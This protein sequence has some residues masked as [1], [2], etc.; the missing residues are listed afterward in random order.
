MN[1]MPISK[2]DVLLSIRPEFATKI[3]TGEKTVELRRRFPTEAVT[4]ATAMIY[5]SSPIQSI[6]GY[7][8][9]EE[10]LELPI[11]KIWNDFG[12]FACISKLHFFSYFKGLDL[13]YAIKLKE[14]VEFKI[15]F[16]AEYLREEF[17]FI[18]PQSF[19]YLPIEYSTL[20][21]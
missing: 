15:P 10:V 2:R 11:N 20:F 8:Q 17:N 3:L 5:S 16:K 12:K 9:I 4:G 13:G 14:V 6:V 21:K 18:P 1:N 7:A 19:R